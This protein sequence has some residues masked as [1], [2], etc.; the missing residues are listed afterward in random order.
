MLNGKNFH[1]VLL[2]KINKIIDQRCRR[3]V[4]YSCSQLT[5]DTPNILFETLYKFFGQF[6]DA[7]KQCVVT[8]KQSAVRSHFYWPTLYIHHVTLLSRMQH[9]K[10]CQMYLDTLETVRWA[11]RGALLFHSFSLFWPFSRFLTKIVLFCFSFFWL[12]FCFCLIGSESRCISGLSQWQ[13]KRA[14]H[15]VLVKSEAKQHE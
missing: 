5:V 15:L 2:T 10:K 13:F 14:Q 8:N 11:V 1:N 12:T 9:F 4:G 6:C 3:V 7:V